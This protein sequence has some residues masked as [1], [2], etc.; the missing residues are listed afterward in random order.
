LE[1][2]RSES[3]PNTSIQRSH[4]LTEVETQPDVVTSQQKQE[5]A[6]RG[7]KTTENVRY[8]QTIS[9]QG[10]GGKTTDSSGSANQGMLRSPGL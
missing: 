4:C 5:K 6:E 8:G 1:V 3:S 2:G 7:E 10:M 9:E